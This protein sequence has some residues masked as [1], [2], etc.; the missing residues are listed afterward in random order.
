MAETE[1]GARARQGRRWGHLERAWPELPPAKRYSALDTR[2]P[3]GHTDAGSPCPGPKVCPGRVARAIDALHNNQLPEAPEPVAAEAEA[4]NDCDDCG[5]KTRG[6]VKLA[7]DNPSHRCI[8]VWPRN[9][10]R[11]SGA[12]VKDSRCELHVR[13]DTAVV[14]RRRWNDSVSY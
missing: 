2:C 13:S 6:T 3:T 9:A 4:V 14:L 5:R 7:C 10:K 12:V 11:C 1:L 8:F